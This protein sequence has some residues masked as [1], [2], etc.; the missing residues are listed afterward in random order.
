MIEL[1]NKFITQKDKNLI[2]EITGED[3]MKLYNINEWDEYFN[4]SKHICSSYDKIGMH[5]LR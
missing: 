5:I 4:K 1:I 2:S 3:F